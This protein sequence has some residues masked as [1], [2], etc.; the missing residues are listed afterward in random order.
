MSAEQLITAASP[1]L[2]GWYFVF[3]VCVYCLALR[4]AISEEADPANKIEFISIASLFLFF[5]V[6]W[7][8]ILI[9]WVVGGLFLHPW[10]FATVANYIKKVLT[11]EP[12]E[13]ATRGIKPTQ[14]RLL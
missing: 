6:I 13:I 14:P 9:C 2:L 1:A 3:G 12:E 11:E 10:E 4:L 7:L 8:P 5:A